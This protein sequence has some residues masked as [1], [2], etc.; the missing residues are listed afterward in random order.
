MLLRPNSG[1]IIASSI[2]CVEGAV[3]RYIIRRL[4]IAI[5]V[6]FGLT[7]V[8][9]AMTAVMPGDYVDTLISPDKV[10]E[11]GVSPEALARLREHYGFNK[12]IHERYLIWLRELVLHGN[13]GNSLLSGDPVLSEIGRRLPRTLQLT[14]P[15]L[16]LAMTLGTLIGVVQALHLQSFF[17]NLA[18]LLA[19]LWM[20][21][22]SFVFAIL[23]VYI[24][25]LK[26][27]IFPTGGAEPLRTTSDEALGLLTHLRYMI[28]PLLMLT[29]SAIPSY[30]RF[31]RNSLLEVIHSDYITA[32]RSK[33]LTEKIIT[34]RHA[35][36]NALMP[37]I[38]ITGLSIPGLIGGAF[39][40]E[41]VFVW[42]GMGKWVMLGIGLR[43]Y[44]AIVGM[45]L[46]ASTLVLMSNLMTDI[47][48]AWAD[49]RIRY[50]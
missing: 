24:F 9:F 18:N 14:V 40:I 43:D 23:S 46:V 25:A 29:V 47:A 28:L 26:I 13:L 4:L 22:P 15:A 3:T 50:D 8:T 45:N 11:L 32:A 37:L 35:L 27:P 33:G 39:I 12:P 7:V 30:M 36:R 41:T 10:I 34:V 31:A 5:P 6:L 42:P 17:D 38:T 49:P 19:F 44:P 2:Y 48:Y 1:R 16:F 21:V 20:S